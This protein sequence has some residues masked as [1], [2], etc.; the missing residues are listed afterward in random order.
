MTTNIG[1]WI[2]HRKAVIVKITSQGEETTTILSH[3]DKQPGRF[4]GQR[5]TAPYD[6]NMVQPDDV[7]DRKFAQ[8][9]HRYYQEIEA[10]VKGARAVFIFGPG[11]AKGEL[12][13]HLEAALPKG[14]PIHV[15]TTD[16]L[17][18]SLVAAKVR[19][20]FQH[21]EINHPI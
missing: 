1:L 15:E 16:K 21:Q 10:S 14:S 4:D 19:A 20:Y 5:S 6:S 12:R 2:D 3:A 7:T 17:T 9:L 11:E 13:K 18:D 8:H